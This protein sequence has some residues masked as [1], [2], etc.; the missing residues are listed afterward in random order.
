MRGF[1][2]G[3]DG[4]CR[5]SFT[6]QEAELLSGLALQVASLLDNRES[7]GA[8]SAVD[9][10]LPDAYRD[11]SEHA[12]EFRRFTEEELAT[13]KIANALAV[14]EA[15]SDSDADSVDVELDA[16]GSVAWLRALTDIRLA[17]AARLGIDSE[18][19]AAASDGG[20]EELLYAIYDWLGYLQESLVAAV[21]V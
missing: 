11:N 16:S 15:L 18:H 6:A 5:A 3:A 17:L 20:E 4:R 21:D 12:A 9:R 2:A 14:S 10:L 8:D 7:P 1:I 13:L 19:E